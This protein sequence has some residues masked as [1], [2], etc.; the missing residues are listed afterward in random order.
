MA[1]ADAAVSLTV[2]EAGLEADGDAAGLGDGRVCVVVTVRV[3]GH[4]TPALPLTTI[5]R[6]LTPQR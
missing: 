6:K 5:L 4:Q 2:G 1:G 3:I